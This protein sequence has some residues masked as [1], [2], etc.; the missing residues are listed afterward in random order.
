M[1]ILIPCEW[2]GEA[3]APARGFGRM[4]DQHFVI[5]ERYVLEPVEDRSAKSHK[6]FFA[7]IREAWVN[8]PEHLADGI[9]SPEALRKRALIMTGYRDETSIVC[10]SAAEAR[11][12]AAFVRPTDEFSIVS[13]NGPVVIRWTAKSQSTRAMDKAM[14]QRSKSDVLDWISDLIGSTAGQIQHE[15]GRAA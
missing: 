6:Q 5:G 7:A 15:A 13:V 12:V 11:R 1:S 10:A 9:A 2:D 4:C 8:L 14:F 3:F